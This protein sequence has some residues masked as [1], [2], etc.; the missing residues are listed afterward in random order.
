MHFHLPK[1]LHGWREFSG[2]VGIIVIGVL[3]A[4][5]AEQLVERLN[6]R[7]VARDTRAAITSEVNVDLAG[8]VRRRNAEPCILRRLAELQGLLVTWSRSGQFDTPRWISA[9][10]ATTIELARFDAAA[11]AGRL[12]LLTGDE[13]YRIGSVVNFLRDFKGIQNEERMIWGRLRALDAGAGALSALDRAQL[14][15]S[16]QD[17]LTA[18]YRARLD[19]A[20]SLPLAEGFGFHPDF[21]ILQ[22]RIGK[23][24]RN[25]GVPGSSMPVASI[26]LPMQT[27]AS[28]A[29]SNLVT[30]IPL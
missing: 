4:L 18:D 5:G 6:D 9:P 10:P 13:Q 23:M 11:S 8:V 15:L 28:Q 29:E 21:E 19:V 22:Q 27:P 1:P 30:P 14:R 12:T 2:E 26:C 3:I 7:A 24:V 20:Q 16:L 17:A 25:T